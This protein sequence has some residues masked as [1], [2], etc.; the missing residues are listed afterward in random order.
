MYNKNI[1]IIGSLLLFLL[2]ESTLLKCNASMNTNINYNNSIRSNST[3]VIHIGNN[4]RYISNNKSNIKNL[5][6]FYSH[7]DHMLIVNGISTNPNTHTIQLNNNNYIDNQSSTTIKDNKFTLSIS[8]KYLPNKHN[9]GIFING[10]T[11]NMTP[12]FSKELNKRSIISNTPKLIKLQRHNNKS[13][14][15]IKTNKGTLKIYQKN[16]LFRHKNVNKGLHKFIIPKVKAKDIR[17]TLT[18]N[19]KLSSNSI[20]NKFHK[21]SYISKNELKKTYKNIRKNGIKSDKKYFI[22]G[23]KKGL[24]Q[25]PNINT[26]MK[27]NTQSKKMYES[28]FLYGYYKR[29][30]ITYNDYLNNMHNL[31]NHNW[32]VNF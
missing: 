1:F 3:R 29:R 30:F 16:K 21:P 13:L 23:L 5:K 25:K 6:Y 20:I 4:R 2:L 31:T 27:F 28:G 26:Y 10:Y 11:N 9:S 24:K 12:L 19:G 22:K 15:E 32:C 17:L 8:L 7:K 14:I 18:E